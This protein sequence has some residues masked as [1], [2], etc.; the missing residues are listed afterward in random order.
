ML[1]T[2]DIRNSSKKDNEAFPADL[3][4]RRSVQPRSSWHGRKLSKK[5]R[6]VKV[7]TQRNLGKGGS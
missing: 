3:Q 5:G 6:G 2:M 4:K 1:K 7:F